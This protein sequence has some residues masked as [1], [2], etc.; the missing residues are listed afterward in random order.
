MSDELLQ[1]KIKG[2]HLLILES[3]SALQ[4]YTICYRMFVE[5]GSDSTKPVLMWTGLFEDR[6]EEV[7]SKEGWVGKEIQKSDLNMKNG[8]LK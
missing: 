7:I 5:G 3:K 8:D 1:H 4:V 6:I 2:A